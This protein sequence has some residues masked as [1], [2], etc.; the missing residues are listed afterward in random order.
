MALAGAGCHES[1]DIHESS[2]VKG[3]PCITCHQAAYATANAPLHTNV[4]PTTCDS[5]HQTSGWVPVRQIPD[6]PWFPLAN[7]HIGPD[8]KACHTKS[9][10]PGDTPNDCAACHQKDYASA[11]HPLHTGFPTDCARCH[12]DQGFHPSKF[13]HPWPLMGSHAPTQCV[14]C[15]TGTPPT[16]KVST[17][18]VDCHQ[19]DYDKSPYPGHQTF[20]KSCTDCHTAKSLGWKPALEGPHPETSFPLAP[21][22]P[23]AGVACQDCHQLGAGSSKQGAN[24]DCVHCH[25]GDHQQP[26][27]DQVHVKNGV[28]GYPS[29]PQ[30]VSFC[31]GCHPNGKKP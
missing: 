20:P 24:T 29:G 26:A 14:Q 11:Q 15:H 9:Y 3:K 27:I 7:K 6:H 12:D 10:K 28:P 31:L 5:C 23:H 4:M 30:P 17:S 21:P 25:N 8:C 16:W 22:S 18:C 13:V 2:D 1:S 19:A